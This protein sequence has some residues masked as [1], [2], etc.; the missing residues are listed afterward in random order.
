M[1]KVS[2]ALAEALSGKLW[3]DS[4]AYGKRLFL[5]PDEDPW[6]DPTRFVWLVGQGQALLGSDVL[7][8]RLEDAYGALL[9]R[10]PDVL[11]E[12][13]G[14]SAG[15]ILR[16]LFREETERA[17]IGEI[18]TALRGTYRELPLVLQMPSPSAWV[19]WVW[20][21]GLGK[22]PGKSAKT[23]DTDEI[24]A[25][26]MYLADMLRAFADCGVD[27]I[28]LRENSGEGLGERFSLYQPV[29]NVAHHYRWSLGLDVPGKG[30]GGDLPQADSGLDL[31][32]LDAKATSK[33][34]MPLGLRVPLG[35][36][37]AGKTPPPMGACGFR[38]AEIPADGVPETVL[39][40]VKALR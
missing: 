26:A 17:R 31:C 24:E 23:P 21:L 25:V 18:L 36:W 6:A 33:A 35:Y 10:Q 30:G 19:E 14:R 9:A 4:L 40:Q 29:V 11:G 3:I 13:A 12:A 16:A 34:D 27:G 22:P 28:L 15:A 7:G 1:G 39:T 37:K 2:A 5:N 8:L 38:F 20:G 32:I